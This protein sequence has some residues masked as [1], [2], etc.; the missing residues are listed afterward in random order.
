MISNLV[1]AIAAM[2]AAA[3]LISALKAWLSRQSNSPIEIKVGSNHVTLDLAREL[4]PEQLNE[5]IRAAVRSVAQ[6]DEAGSRKIAN[7][8]HAASQNVRTSQPGI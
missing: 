2:G 4:S 6:G 1:V 8:S 7:D 5:F 3:P